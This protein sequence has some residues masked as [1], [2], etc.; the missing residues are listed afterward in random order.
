MS[1]TGSLR[2][3][4][5]GRLL[6]LSVVVLGLLAVTAVA[7]RAPLSTL[8]KTGGKTAG[9]LQIET[10]PWEFALIGGGGLIAF[11]CFLSG[12]LSRRTPAA[13]SLS[14]ILR[15]IAVF[16]TPLIASLLITGAILGAHRRAASQTHALGSPAPSRPISPPHAAF[17][18]PVW[19]SW[20]ILGTL[21]AG[22]L[23]FVVGVSARPRRGEERTLPSAAESAVTAALIDLDTIADPRLAIIAAYQG[24]E[25]RL[26]EAGLPRAAPEAPREYLGRVASALQVD[27][28][29][30]GTLT[31]LFE[32][33]KFS[34]R[35][36]DDAARQR[37]I[38][39]LR[40]LQGQL[41]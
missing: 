7:S 21:V 18:V 1:S 4:R 19:V 39:A 2:E 41:A 37:A 22:V 24:M 28:T 6:G 12:G 23:L 38:T 36:L 17:T 14:S 26:A 11:I 35:Q 3:T 25:Q 8:G 10:S 32:A 5:G 30:L 40:A 20:G 9:G 16:L 27:P 29:P 13:G 15:Q 34:L 31:T 33:A